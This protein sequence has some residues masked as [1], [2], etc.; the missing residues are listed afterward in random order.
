MSTPFPP[1]PDSEGD[2]PPYGSPGGP[3]QAGEPTYG[4]PQ[5]GRPQYG[6]PQYGQPQYGQPSYG[7]QPHG[8]GFGG[9]GMTKP[10]NNL[11]WA[12]LSTLLC[13]LPLG[14]ASIVSAA[15]VDGAWASGDYAGALHHSEKAKSWAIRSA[16]ASAVVV[17][18]YLLFVLA[19]F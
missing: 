11:V 9:P 2:R 4:Q 1:P 10:S 5:Y 13:C 18:L 8:G 17:A 12:I 3:A 7:Q 15:K 6:K 16:V 14:V 19:A